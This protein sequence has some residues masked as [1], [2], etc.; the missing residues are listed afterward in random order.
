VPPAVDLAAAEGQLPAGAC[1]MF[2]VGL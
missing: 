1:C 2:F